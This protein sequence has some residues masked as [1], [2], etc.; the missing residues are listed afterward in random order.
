MAAGDLK[1]HVVLVGPPPGKG[2]LTLE[3]KIDGTTTD[4]H[5]VSPNTISEYGNEPTPGSY[6]VVLR[7]GLNVVAQ[8]A[9]RITR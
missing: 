6:Q 5:I 9:F 2:P 4:G 7:Q 3:W 1:A 8:Y